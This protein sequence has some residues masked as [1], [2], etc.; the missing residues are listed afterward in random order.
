MASGEEDLRSRHSFLSRV[1]RGGGHWQGGL[2]GFKLSGAGFWSIPHATTMHAD[3][4][5]DRGVKAALLVPRLLCTRA[6]S[7][8]RT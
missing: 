7:R 6:A 4:R 3:A 5:S 1:M 2:S 8:A